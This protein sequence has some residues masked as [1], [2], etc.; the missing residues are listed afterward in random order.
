MIFR[1]WP[2]SIIAILQWGA[3]FLVAGLG[4]FGLAVLLF[5]FIDWLW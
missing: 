3:L 2:R 1:K 5:T 4:G